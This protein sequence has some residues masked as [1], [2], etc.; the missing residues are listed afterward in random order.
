[1]T[2]GFCMPRA[3]KPGQ[4]SEWWWIRV[5][6]MCLGKRQERGTLQC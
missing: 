2:A 1:V 6:K 4:A 5:W 3:G